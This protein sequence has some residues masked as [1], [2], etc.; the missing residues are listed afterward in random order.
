M[1]IDGN[2]S[3]TDRCPVKN[4]DTL[5]VKLG[6]SCD[7]NAGSYV[8]IQNPKD[9][10][11]FYKIYG[12]KLCNDVPLKPWKDFVSLGDLDIEKLNDFDFCSKWVNKQ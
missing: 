4:N 12:D 1:Y 7:N 11:T 8:S 2:V 9:S 6:Y 5:I 3:V 10:G